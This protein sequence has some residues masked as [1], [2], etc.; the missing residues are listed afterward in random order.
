[1]KIK[2]IKA[3]SFVKNL[4]KAYTEGI[5]ADTPAN[6]KLGRVGMIY[7]AYAEK[8]KGEEKKEDST[9]EE[10]LSKKEF[11]KGSL[12]KNSVGEDFK[13]EITEVKGTKDFGETAMYL[14]NLHSRNQGTYGFLESVR[15]FIKDNG[16]EDY[17]KVEG[18]G[19]MYQISSKD[20]K[21][22]LQVAA[23]ANGKEIFFREPGESDYHRIGS[24]SS[25]V[26]SYFKKVCKK[27]E[28]HYPT[29]KQV[30]DGQSALYN[31]VKEG[32]TITKHEDAR[33]YKYVTFADK[34]SGLVLFKRSYSDNTDIDE[35]DLHF[36]KNLNQG[37]KNVSELKK[38]AEKYNIDLKYDPRS[39]A[40][41]TNGFQSYKLGTIPLK[42][43][44]KHIY[45]CPATGSI[46]IYTSSN[47]YNW[48]SPGFKYT[49]SEKVDLNNPKGN[50]TLNQLVKEFN[51][52]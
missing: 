19:G 52:K 28:E 50:Y 38:F 29:T 8:V 25:T 11:K 33:K 49:G 7:A 18:T 34:N 46:K 23:S 24:N 2:N 31:K 12:Q 39:S 14:V 4:T 47:S 10:N 32:L 51:K 13:K 1:M 37:Q 40:N 36:I 43:N 6:R 16:V 42:S 22:I 45:Y 15:N 35:R 41:D 27:I 44:T 20:G 5:Y 48:R 3:I 30:I 17:F 9:K 26:D 21:T